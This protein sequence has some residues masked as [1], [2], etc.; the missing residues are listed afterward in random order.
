MTTLPVAEAAE[1]RAYARRL[2]LLHPR[3]L[4][5]SLL[6]YS[7]AAATGLVAP[8]M[9]G[10]LVQDAGRH[11]GTAATAGAVICAAVAAQALLERCA[12]ITSTRLSEKI[13]ARLR[14]DFVKKVL[15]LPL[16]TV[17]RAGAGDLVA[18]TTRDID[19]L[20]RT[21]QR[22]AP[23][24]L[25]ALCTILLT[26]GAIAL[27]GPLLLLPSL[28]AVPVLWASTRWYLRRARPGY[29]RASASYS[30]LTEGLTETVD[31]A[32]TVEGL[33]IADRRLA[34]TDR[35]I[36]ESYAAERHTL[37]LRSVYLPFADT[38][39]MLPVAATLVVGGLFYV[40]GAVSLGAAI[41]ATL[42]VQQII[43]PVDQLLYWMDELQVG[44]A[45]LARILGVGHALPD[46]HTEAGQDGV[47]TPAGQEIE[48]RGVHY[49]YR[50]GHDVLRE[51]NLVVRPGERLAIVGP[52]GAG[53]STLGRL[54]AGIHTPRT[55]SV[56]VGGV[57]LDALPL[58]EL[59]RQVALV[60]QEHHVFRGTLRDN[61][62]IAKP[63]AGD[64]ELEKALKTIDAWEW[65]SALGL[66]TEVGSGAARLSPAQ[67]QQLALARLVLADPHTLVLDEATAQLDPRTARH[68][69]RSL[70]AVLEGRT[71]IAIAHRLHTAHDADRVVVLDGGRI[72]EAGPHR[73]LIG[74]SGPYAALWESWHGPDGGA[75]ERT[76][77]A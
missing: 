61:L 29:L 22:A 43:G 32:R 64:D 18:R 73:E 48:V 2:A 57:P 9:L 66:D 31:G 49:A 67:A 10:D 28:V 12:T 76:G 65:A 63:E 71:V 40:N 1:V 53:K 46:R 38:A 68:L 45:S 69:E 72:T 14:E 51:V 35:D 21:V 19:V 24:T 13:L 20:A 47:H 36:A 8:W 25:I 75:A 42:Y 39:Y 77:G 7:L 16:A 74:R 34:R 6:L 55:G 11:A 17:E 15:E 27:A 52:S 70:A 33:A 41:A 37:W 60:S 54:L 3:Q 4:A 62:L 30:R 44:G 58:T 56:T 26:L 23:D 50:E 59:R 5:A